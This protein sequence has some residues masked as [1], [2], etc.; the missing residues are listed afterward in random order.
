MSSSSSPATNPP[1]LRTR[2]SGAEYLFGCHVGRAGLKEIAE[3]WRALAALLPRRSFQHLPEWYQSYAEALETH[4][5]ALRFYTVHAGGALQAIIPLKATKIRLMRRSVRVLTLPFDDHLPFADIVCKPGVDVAEL[6]AA[7]LDHLRRRAGTRWDLLVL[8]RVLDDAPAARLAAG[9]PS[10]ARAL[11]AQGECD[12]IA[13]G[14]DAS[15]RALISGKFVRDLRRRAN[16]LRQQGEVEFEV[17]SGR[18][19]LMRA[20]ED[21]LAVES[22]GWKGRA[23]AGTAIALNPRLVNFY[24]AL[25]EHF[26]VIG[27]CEI[28]LLRVAGRCVAAQFALVVDGAWYLLKMGYD[29]TLSAMAP[30]NLLV[31]HALERHC[32]TRG[33]VEVNLVSDA[34][35]HQSWN[36]A[37]TAVHT[38]YVANRTMT[39]L[40]LVALL[41]A[42]E[43]LRARHAR[44]ATGSRADVRTAPRPRGGD[45]IEGELRAAREAVA[46]S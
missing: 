26:A 39:G 5:G 14:E 45:G 38:H 17:A 37:S 18:A 28:S 30:G 3:D 2:G 46:Q 35:W 4:D 33:V 25:I 23:G 29:E 9:T 44:R 6:G 22:S 11:G 24:R 16:K 21:F 40:A 13:L 41:R 7:L 1:P 34:Q 19:E 12:F 43:R 42:K 20:F 15:V 27:G 10:L 8:P 36:P 31:E 32:S